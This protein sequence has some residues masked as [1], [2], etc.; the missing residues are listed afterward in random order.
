MSLSTLYLTLLLRSASSMRH[1]RNCDRVVRMIS[2]ASFSA[3]AATATCVRTKRRMQPQPEGQRPSLLEQG[4]LA[5]KW[6]RWT[7]WAYSKRGSKKITGGREM[8][9]FFWRDVSVSRS[10]QTYVFRE[11]L[12]GKLASFRLP[13]GANCRTALHRTAPHCAYTVCTPPEYL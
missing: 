8:Y 11:M 7:L 3:A 10:E 2:R 13:P 5:K 6:C 1:T 9:S 12:L 4:A